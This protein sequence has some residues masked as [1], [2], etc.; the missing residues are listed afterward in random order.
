MQR[1]DKAHTPQKYG[2][3]TREGI[4]ELRLRLREINRQTA[5]IDKMLEKMLFAE[6]DEPEHVGYTPE[7]CG[8][9]K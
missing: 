7:Q 4:A 1:Q 6:Y 5:E 9:E 3:L 2:S 8:R